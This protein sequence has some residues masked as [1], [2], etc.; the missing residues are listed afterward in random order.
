MANRYKNIYKLTPNQ[1]IKKAALFRY[2]S[3][4]L[5]F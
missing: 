1:Q 5:N 3:G 2:M 4:Y